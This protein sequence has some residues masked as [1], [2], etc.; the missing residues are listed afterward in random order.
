VLAPLSGNIWKILVKP[1]Q[2][3]NEGDTLLILEAMKMETEI[4]AAR[5]GIVTNISI[6]EGDAV[7]VGQV[8]LFLA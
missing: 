1:N 8:L 3:L 7:T 5:S 6:K 4:K 2:S